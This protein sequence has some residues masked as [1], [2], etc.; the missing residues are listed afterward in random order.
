[1]PNIAGDA[2]IST[3]SSKTDPAAGNSV[4]GYSHLAIGLGG[5]VDGQAQAVASQELPQECGFG[6]GGSRSRNQMPYLPK[7][8]HRVDETLAAGDGIAGEFLAV[9]GGVLPKSRLPYLFQRSEV[10]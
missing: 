7:S 10:F 9:V 5:E 6:R 4:A 2:A 1:M 3:T 8:S